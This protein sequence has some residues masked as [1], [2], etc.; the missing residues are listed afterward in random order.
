MKPN[1]PTKITVTRIITY[2]CRAWIS[3]DIAEAA[4]CRFH[5]SAWAAPQA[6][7]AASAHAAKKVRRT[8]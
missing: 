7:A 4:G 8:D 6:T 3:A 5:S 1:T 2:S